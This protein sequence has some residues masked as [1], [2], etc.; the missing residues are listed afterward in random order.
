MDNEIGVFSTSLAIPDP[1]AAIAKIAELGMPVLQMGPL[2]NEWYGAEGTERLAAAL[3]ERALRVSAVCAAFE[4]ESYADIPTVQRTVGYV[5]AE[6]MDERLEHTKRCADLAA[7]LSATVLTTHVG[8][9]PA[10]TASADYARVVRAAREIAGYCASVGVTFGLE[11]GQEAAP[12]LLGFLGQVDR[13]NVKVNFDPANLILYGTGRPLEALDAAADYVV[14]VHV[15]DG[16]PPTG[17]QQL[18]TEVPLGEGEVNIAAYLG[19]LA[20]IGYRGPLIIEREAGSDRI[21][22]VAR[23]R[24]L[25]QHLMREIA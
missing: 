6:T 3:K 9:I 18:G 8:F 10:D 25:L 13:S 15:K 22:D 2:P 12:E 5:P 16:L 7:A 23:G 14:H 24:E 4:G 21:G 1:L 17:P 20:A 11:T 19:K